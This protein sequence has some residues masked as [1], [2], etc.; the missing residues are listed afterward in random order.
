MLRWWAGTADL[1]LRVAYH[2]LNPSSSWPKRWP[3]L[4]RRSAGCRRSGALAGDSE[5]LTR[6]I[7]ILNV[8]KNNIKSAETC[9]IRKSTR[10]TTPSNA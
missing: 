6:T 7:K 5:R 8:E 10:T 2:S 1:S 4:G 9:T 3:P